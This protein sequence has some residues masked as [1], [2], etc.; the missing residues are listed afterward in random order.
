MKNLSSKSD[1]SIFKDFFSLFSSDTP[2]FEL[3]GNKKHPKPDFFDF[4]FHIAPIIILHPII[5]THLTTLKL[6][7]SLFTVPI[8]LISLTLD[9]E[10]HKLLA[11]LSKFHY[12]K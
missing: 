11:F 2:V 12:T 8:R 10:I 3:S 6:Q 4:F 7:L 9:Q 1:F 5:G